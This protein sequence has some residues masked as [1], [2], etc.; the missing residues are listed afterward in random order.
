MINY[1]E[2]RC[3]NYILFAEEGVLFQ[4]DGIDKDGLTVVNETECTWIEL[5]TFEPV[6]LTEGWL[7]R[8][9]FTVPF[10]SESWLMNCEGFVID[11]TT[12][13]QIITSSIG[14]DNVEKEVGEPLEFVHQLQNRFFS[15]TGE[16]LTLKE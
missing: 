3:G 12:K 2:L 6:P 9:G 14:Y 16:E 5:D 7:L 11:K 4:V 1:K 8:F 10:S 13:Y 15:M